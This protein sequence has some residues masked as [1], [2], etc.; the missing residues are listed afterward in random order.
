MLPL[1]HGEASVPSKGGGSA[2][3]GQ[4]SRPRRGRW[5]GRQRGEQGKGEEG[6]E[7]RAHSRWAVSTA[8]RPGNPEPRL[9]GEDDENR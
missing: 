1:G 8:A 7:S 9:L 5:G 6:E 2:V 3:W 4:G